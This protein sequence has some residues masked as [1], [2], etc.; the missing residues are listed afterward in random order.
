[1]DVGKKKTQRLFMITQKRRKNGKV[2]FSLRALEKA[3]DF[4]GKCLGL[5]KSCASSSLASF[6]PGV[7]RHWEEI[8]TT[9][10]LMGILFE[11]PT[12]LR[13]L[14]LTQNIGAE[15]FDID[16][17]TVAPTSERR[18]CALRCGRIDIN[19]SKLLL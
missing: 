15:V 17:H 2:L 14:K 16:I 5:G 3:N 1:M 12:T 10:A 19:G 9:I 11:S 13:L 8:K 18:Q 6:A 7:E 4:Y